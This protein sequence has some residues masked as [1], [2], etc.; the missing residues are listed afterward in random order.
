MNAI[1]DQLEKRLLSS[2]KN[3]ELVEE[4]LKKC[5]SHSKDNMFTVNISLW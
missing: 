2:H 3:K 5:K 1:I 4:D